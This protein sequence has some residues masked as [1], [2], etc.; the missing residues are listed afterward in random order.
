MSASRSVDIQPFVPLVALLKGISNRELKSRMI[1]VMPI[2]DSGSVDQV[3]RLALKGFRKDYLH[4]ILRQY[5]RKT[6]S[7]MRKSEMIDHS[8]SL[9]TP[10]EN[11]PDDGPCTAIVPYVSDYG[12]RAA[13]FPGQLVDFER[14]SRKVAKKKK[15]DD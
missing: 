7:S 11:F 15:K 6:A 4:M 2:R 8:I 12:T 13:D 14:N 3:C 9:N 5:D 10:R 1:E